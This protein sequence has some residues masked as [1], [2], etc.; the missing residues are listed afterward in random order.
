MLVLFTFMSSTADTFVIERGIVPV[1]LLFTVPV[2]L[3]ETIATVTLTLPDV[4]FRFDRWTI[5][6]PTVVLTFV[7]AVPLLATV[8][9]LLTGGTR[10]FRKLAV[11]LPGPPMVAEVAGAMG[12]L[13]T[14]ALLLV[15]HVVNMYVGLGVALIR[16]VEDAFS[17]IVPDGDDVPPTALKVT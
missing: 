2:E 6:F 5:I 8:V 14:I 15:F 9:L 3:P 16:T 11:T 13:I 12:F 4:E 10:G 7:D 1:A 17:Q